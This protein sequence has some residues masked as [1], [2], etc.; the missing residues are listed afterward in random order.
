LFSSNRNGPFPMNRKPLS[1]L[2]PSPLFI[3]SFTQMSDLLSELQNTSFI[4]DLKLR[5]RRL[6]GN[7]R[8]Y[9]DSFRNLPQSA[10]W[11]ER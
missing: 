4:D 10:A 5:H 1:F 11:V 7:L 2:P 3:L 6:S 8:F 9:E